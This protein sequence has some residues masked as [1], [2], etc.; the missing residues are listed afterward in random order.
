MYYNCHIHLFTDADVPNGFLPLG[1]VRILRS[2]AGYK[3]VAGILKRIIFW[4]DRDIFDRYVKFVTT[5]R[6]GSQQ[7]IYERCRSFY[8]DGTRFIA[9]PMDMAYM[10]AGR[11]PRPYPEQLRELYDLSKAYPEVIP[12]VHA[13]CRRP[14]MM[15]LVKQCVEQ[16]GFKGVKLYPPLGVFPYDERY[17]P[18]YA[19]CQEKNLPVITHCSPANPV[20]FKGSDKELMKL[21]ERSKEPVDT[22]GKS[23]KEL[24]SLFTHPGNFRQVAD[25]FPG[26]RI[27]FGH[28]GSQDHWDK[29]IHQPWEE[30]NWL[31]V[32]RD[33]CTERPN[34][35]ADISFT[36]ADMKYFSLLKVLLT[37]ERL[38]RKILFGSDYYMVE[39]ETNERRFGLD[40]RAY[41]GEENFNRIAVQNPTAFL[42]GVQQA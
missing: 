20:H 25:R 35:Y 1:L 21:L 12:F 15:G 31:R 9:L 17:D 6:L 37:D 10:G 3:I 18:L 28:F 16:W 23:L 33:L 32:I 2:A 40:L 34:F 38:S 7:K 5:G 41:L 39:V 26:L 27:C 8:P 36:M 13:D 42:N 30:D 11:V 19:Y 24:C 4:T 14:D 22:K 29:Y